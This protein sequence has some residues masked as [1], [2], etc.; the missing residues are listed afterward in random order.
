MLKGMPQLSELEIS[1]CNL[2]KKVVFED[3]DASTMNDETGETIQFPL[4]HSLSL[5]HLDALECFY[6]HQPTSSPIFL[7]N[8]Q[9]ASVILFRVVFSCNRM[10][11][12]HQYCSEALYVCEGYS[13]ELYPRELDLDASIL[14]NSDPS[15]VLTKRDSDA[16]VSEEILKKD[17][18]LINI[19]VLG[20]L[21]AIVG[22]MPD[23]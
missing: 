7:F 8:N 5:Q 17:E 2:M 11:E 16:Q 23:L 3:D 22:L 12:M 21:P 9:C 19:V 1:Q 4:L 10:L 18:Y 14:V 20:N 13:S 6:S 15:V